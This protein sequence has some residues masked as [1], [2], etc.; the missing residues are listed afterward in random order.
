MLDPRS[1]NLRPTNFGHDSSK[2]T[3][4][5]L[6]SSPFDPYCG[7]RRVAAQLFISGDGSGNLQLSFNAGMTWGLRLNDCATHIKS[8][9]RRIPISDAH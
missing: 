7:R 8:F 2:L 6:A 9:Q 1:S 5:P 3:I 4:K